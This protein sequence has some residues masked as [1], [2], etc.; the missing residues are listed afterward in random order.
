MLCAVRS[1][2]T[3]IG[4]KIARLFASVSTYL[5]FSVCLVCVRVCAQRMRV[6][7]PVVHILREFSW[8]LHASYTL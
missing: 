6:Y 2:R 4:A 8:H 3:E 1:M 7:M 5:V